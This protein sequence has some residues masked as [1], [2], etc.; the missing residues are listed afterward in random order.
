MFAIPLLLT[1]L[2]AA[3]IPVVIH[4][5]HRNRTVPLDWGAMLFL[6]PGAVRQRRSQRLEHWLLML[7]RMA[8]L[9]LLA[10]L[11]AEPILPAGKFNPLVGRAAR[12]VVVV[13]DHS[14]ASGW[15]SG[16]KTVFQRGVALVQRIAR[17][18]GPAD[19]L[20]VVLAQ[21]HPVA[22]TPAPVPARDKAALRRRLL[23]PLRQMAPGLTGSSLPAAIAYARRYA[24]RGDN[25]QKSIFVISDDRTEAWRINQPGLWRAMLGPSTAG[26]SAPPVFD[27][28][29]PP[30]RGADDIAVGGLRVE[31]AIPGVGRRVRILA[32]V[33]NAGPLAQAN[34]PLRLIV[35]GRPLG[36]KRLARLPPDQT[37]NVVFHCRF[38][39]AGSHWVKVVALV[40]DALAADNWSLAA[41]RVWGR[42][43]VLIIDSA[44]TNPLGSTAA[45]HSSRFLRT[46][47]QPWAA[48][49]GD[50]VAGEGDS[51]K[52]ARPP[53]GRAG[54]AVPTVL[55]V[56]A[57]ATADLYA[58]DAVIVNDPPLL[59]ETLLRRLYTYAAA[60]HGV[61]FILGRHTTPPYLR[62]LDH[63]GFT[64]GAL[65]RLAT[66][67]KPSPWLVIRRPHN[68]IF[69]PLARLK[70]NTL[71]NVTLTHWWRWQ[72][73]DPRARVLLT[74]NRGAP[75]VL[76]RSIG[77]TGG[78]MVL[79]TTS[80]DGRWNDWPLQGGSFVPVVNQT[81]YTLALGRRR[82]L[83]RH[84]LQPSDPIVWTG[85]THPTILSASVIGPRGA[86]HKVSPR[87]T[88]NNRYLV[89]WNHTTRP[90][91]YE[92]KFVPASIPQ[93][94]YYSVSIDP[95]QLNSQTLSRAQVAWLMH[96]GYI[97]ARI[98]PRQI[99]AALGV[100]SRGVNLWPLLAAIVL[101][102]LVAETFW[103]R[104]MSYWHTG[105]D[106]ERLAAAAGASAPSGGPLIAEG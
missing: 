2:G 88:V 27:L 87:L 10:L 63:A 53:A 32:P 22:L 83:D 23:A 52:P 55:T 58:Y 84:Y 54:H 65:G 76:Q 49:G 29:T 96:H 25:F 38:T 43:P 78:A 20:G 21:R 102:L 30:G 5:L 39:S 68:P 16:G 74:T 45:L 95:R 101:L 56:S 15:R 81:V 44:M 98:T 34:V 31:P 18:L 37:R 11:L 72:D 7:L 47:L 46:A 59:P 77:N 35:D 9:A 12:D 33:S 75:L 41:V 91:L 79:W 70:Q 73:L 82:L 93:P 67:T 99:T 8:L 24:R 94:V 36:V 106:A 48:G 97:R 57:A 4:L 28:P 51:T 86:V 90:G 6:E 60:G 66:A 80:V 104:R 105:D 17:R 103:C 26:A 13:L 61:W 69:R 71:L 42:M 64:M 50:Q 1:G 89:A 100:I 92:L 40:H 19:T 3:L 62:A 14:L 85:S